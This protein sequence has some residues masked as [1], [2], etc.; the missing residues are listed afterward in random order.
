MNNK[1]DFFPTSFCR[2]TLNDINIKHLQ[3][4]NIGYQYEVFNKPV[5]DGISLFLEVDRVIDIKRIRTLYQGSETEYLTNNQK[6]YYRN[7]NVIVSTQGKELFYKGKLWNSYLHITWEEQ[8]GKIKVNVHATKQYLS[9]SRVRLTSNSS[10]DT[11]LNYLIMHF[12]TELGYIAFHA[13][14]INYNSHDSIVF[15]GLPN[16]GKT[17]TSVSLATKNKSELIAEDIIFINKDTMKVYSCP[18]TMN[19]KTTERFKADTYKGNKVGSIVILSRSDEDSYIR[20]LSKEELTRN[21]INMNYFE[22]SWLHDNLIRH[23]FFTGKASLKSVSEKYNMGQSLICSTVKGLQLG[24]KT[25]ELWIDLLE[26]HIS[27]KQK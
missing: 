17:T 11:L 27:Q 21:V 19:P 23:M 20:N 4:G 2:I 16:T 24:G 9:E 7:C 6:V 10:F 14:A 22:F 12:S 13:A 25:P 15:M 8:Q 3:V 18:F 26:N 5:T 1:V